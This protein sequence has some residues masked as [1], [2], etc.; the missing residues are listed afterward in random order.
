VGHQL[1]ER[2]ALS[3]RDGLEARKEIP[4]RYGIGDGE[5]VRLHARGVSRAIF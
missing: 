1:D 2:F 4:V 3:S 5:D